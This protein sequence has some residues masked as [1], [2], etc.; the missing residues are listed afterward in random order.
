MS[1]NSRP[2]L[3]MRIRA[4][5]DGK[6]SKS[7]VSM[8]TQ[9]GFSPITHDPDTLRQA[10]DQA[11]N[12]ETFQNAIAENLAKLLKP[13]IKSAL[14]TI[15]PVV[16]AVYNHE[17]LLRKT[18]QSVENLLDRLDPVTEVPDEDDVVDTDPSTLATSRKIAI[19]RAGSS[20]DIEGIKQLL[21]EHNA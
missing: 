19:I 7:E 16:E 14:D 1:P 3:T 6:R 9:N 11:I 18:N 5:F 17:V 21:A 20:G 10:I 12:T 2:P 8:P 15:Q 13:S 4:S